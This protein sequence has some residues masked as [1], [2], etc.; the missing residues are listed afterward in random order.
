MVM[1]RI[2]FVIFA[3]LIFASCS[4]NDG[5]DYHYELLATEDAL[6]PEEFEYGKIYD[7]TVK[8]IVPDDCYIAS[9][10]LYEYDATA[11][12]IAVISLVVEENSCEPLELEQELNIRVHALQ[13]SPYIFRFW[14]GEDDNGDPIYLTIEVPVLTPSD[15]S[16]HESKEA[17]TKM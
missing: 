7:I 13:T 11:R 4:D 15:E 2:F 8:Y 6:V 14:Q 16:A 1:K 5:S 9:D 10:I 17:H 3:V 12:N